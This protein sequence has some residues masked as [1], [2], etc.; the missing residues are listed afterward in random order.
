MQRTSLTL[1]IVIL[2][3]LSTSLYAGVILSENFD[4]LTPQEGATLV[5]AF[6]TINNTNVDIVAN[7]GIFGFLCQPPESGN[8]IDMDG[9]AGPGDAQGQLQSNMLFPAG[10]YLLSFDLIGSQRGTT[11]A[12]T[13]TFGN[14]TQTFTLMSSDDSSGIVVNQPVIL[15]SP[16]YLLFVSDTPG[17]I[18]DLLD[19]VVV[20]TTTTTTPEPSTLLLMGSALLVAIRFRRW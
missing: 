15:T 18:G 4:E 6:H 7:G 11:A 1:A 17:W 5:G 13:V 8:C 16:G 2:C 19:N 14:Y 12:T 20:S 3:C 9:G 10:S